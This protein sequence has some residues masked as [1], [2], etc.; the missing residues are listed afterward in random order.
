MQIYTTKIAVAMSHIQ[1]FF[2]AEKNNTKFGYRSV[3]E[4]KF[5][6]KTTHYVLLNCDRIISGRDRKRNSEDANSLSHT[7]A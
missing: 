7:L 5:Q 6:G 1:H 3:S 4:K 2:S